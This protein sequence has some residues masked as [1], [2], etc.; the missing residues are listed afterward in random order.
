[1]PFDAFI[2]HTL[3]FLPLLLAQH[4]QGSM[5]EKTITISIKEISNSSP[6]GLQELED[7]VDQWGSSFNYI[8]ASAAIVKAGNLQ[9]VQPAAATRLLD[10]LAVVWDTQLPSAGARNMANVLWACGKLRYTNPQLWSST[11]KAFLACFDNQGQRAAQQVATVLH[12]LA[13]TAMANKG[14]VPGVPRADLEAA[15][16]QLLEYMRILAM[17]PGLDDV[18]PQH[19]S[20]TLWACAKLRINPGDAALNSLLQAMSRPQMLEQAVPQN[21]VNTLWATSEL[22]MRCGWQPAVMQ[23]VWE[24]LLDEPQLKRIADTG[25]P[26]EVSNA[27][28]ALSRLSTPAPAVAVEARAA[29]AAP[30]VSK[31]LA[32][33]CILQLLQGKVAQHVESWSSQDVA[34]SMWGC[35]VLGVRDV[36]FLDALSAS[37]HGWLPGA[38]AA[39]LRQVSGACKM[40]GYDNEQLL[41]DVIQHS[42]QLLQRQHTKGQLHPS[43]HA[44]LVGMAAYV[45][46]AVASLGLQQLA[47]EV[48]QLMAS[49]VNV[50]QHSGSVVSPDSKFGPAAGYL[51]EVHIWLVGEQLLD[52]RGLAGL[53]TE[54]QLAEARGI[55]EAYH[56]GQ[57]LAVAD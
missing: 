39:E 41:A 14:Q 3:G 28:I 48:M 9:R 33:H 55:A 43:D 50:Q 42:K 45:S 34:N 20:N 23:R 1:L 26:S 19:W 47:G 2:K 29:T 12:G 31:E 21:I 7:I 13:N 15:V 35:A 8:H 38:Y 17:Q 4:V 36:A 25:V 49:S 57:Q 10:R 24:R 46:N 6:T 52:G 32:R 30:V 54:Q 40:L 16:R 53:L 18:L 11:L 5:L 44:R 37:A 51:W 22:R 56:K 27:M